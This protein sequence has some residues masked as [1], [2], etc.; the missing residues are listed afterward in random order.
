VE[1]EQLFAAQS[2]PDRKIFNYP[3]SKVRNRK[4][5]RLKFNRQFVIEPESGAILLL[6]FIV[7]R[8]N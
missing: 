5:S 2:Y 1:Q 4:F 3:V 6:I 8:R 7:L